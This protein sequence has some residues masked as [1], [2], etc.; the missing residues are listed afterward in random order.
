MKPIKTYSASGEDMDFRAES[1]LRILLD[2]RKIKKDP[3]RLKKALAKAK[4]QK[5]AL[6]AIAEVT[7]TRESKSKG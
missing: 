5:D 7:S 6:D 3:N 2:A 4:E 1:D